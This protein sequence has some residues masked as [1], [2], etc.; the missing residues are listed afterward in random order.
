MDWIRF[1]SWGDRH[2]SWVNVIRSLLVEAAC[3]AAR[4]RKNGRRVCETAAA[5]SYPARG[6][7]SRIGKMSDGG[8]KLTV[9]RRRPELLPPSR[10]Y[11]L[12]DGDRTGMSDGGNLQPGGRERLPPSISR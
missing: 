7:P 9:S 6:G 8:S 4:S 5:R 1:C 2:K 10:S 3:D 11:Q 12:A